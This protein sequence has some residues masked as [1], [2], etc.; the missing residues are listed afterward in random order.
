MALINQHM[1]AS[2]SVDVFAAITAAVNMQN[3]KGRFDDR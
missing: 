2:M 3:Q 1:Q